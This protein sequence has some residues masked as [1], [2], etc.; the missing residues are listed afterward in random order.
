MFSLFRGDLLDLWFDGPVLAVARLAAL[1]GAMAG[2]VLGTSR[3][4]R[5]VLQ[6]VAGD[7]QRK[8]PADHQS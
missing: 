1:A 8:P 5:A 4:V 7:A 3:G 6:I 2:Q